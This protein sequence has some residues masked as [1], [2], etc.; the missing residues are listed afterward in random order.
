M[1]QACY[2]STVALIALALPAAVHAQSSGSSSTEDQANSDDVIVVVADRIPGQVDTNV[3]PVLELNSEEIA[4]YGANSIADL[5]AALAPQTN[6]NRGRGGGQPVFLINGVRV[7]SFREFFAYPPEAIEKTEVL[8]EEVAQKFGF[9]PDRRVVNFVL[10]N[11]YSAITL[12]GEYEQP[13]RGG[14]SVNEQQVT[15]LKITG[16]GR[17]NVNAER[18]AT[19]LLTEAERNIIQT[20]ASIPG[21]PTDPDPAAFRSLVGEAER[22]EASANYAKA[23]VSSGSSLSLNA[24]INRS[25]TTGLSGLNTVVL[26]RGTDSVIRTFGEDD[27]LATRARTDSFSTAGSY[28]LPV[29]G[30]TLTATADANFTDTRTLIDRR[31]DVTQ[32]VADAASG[33]LDIRGVLPSL[34]DAGFD[35]ANRETATL[36]SKLTLTGSPL[37]LPGGEVQTTLDA[38][39]RWNRIKSD[40]TRSGTAT[41]LSRNRVSTGLNVTVPVTSRREGFLD[42]VGSITLN[43]NIGIDEISDFGTLK[44]WTAGVTWEPVDGLD[45]SAT[46]VWRE[47][48]P[49]LS[50]LGNPQIVSLNVPTFDLTNNTTELVSVTSGGNPALLAEQQSDWSFSANWRL[51]FIE[52]GRLN[53]TY[54]VNRSSNVASN[55][56]FLTPEIEAAFPDRVTR[57]TAGRL[58][59]LDVRPVNFFETRSKLLTFGINLGGQIGKAPARGGPPAGAAS[60]A[61]AAGGG[62]SG[63]PAGQA[64]ASSTAPGA[65]EP[66]PGGGAGADPA[67]ISEERR[68]SFMALR[69]KICAEDGEAFLLRLVEAA[70]KGE[71]IPE[72]P[73]F[74]PAQAERM[75]ARLR[76]DDGSINV[77][78]V[79]GFRTMM[80]SADSPFGGRPAGGPPAQASG[81][82]ATASGSSSGSGGSRAAAFFGGGGDSRVRYFLSLTHSIELERE[83]LIAPGGPLLDLLDGDTLTSTGNARQSSRLEAGLF[84]GGTGFRLTGR[85]TGKAR[86]N[87]TGLPGSTDLFVD[88]LAR[89]DIRIFADMGQVLKKDDGVFKN[90]RISFVVDNVFDGRRL[91]RD[92]NGDTPIGFQPLLIDPTGRYL[93]IDIRKLF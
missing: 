65:G 85:Y 24:T 34:P 30:F 37:F 48:A 72:L 73:E 74:D 43:G 33:V 91:V 81:G 80:C 78:R 19:S 16:G 92:S 38:G 58:T 77:E 53:A 10:K 42:A 47:E 86:I 75:L 63:S 28:N 79:K 60:A 57:D 8:P 36:D 82:P 35:T 29:G 93:G 88:D 89:F 11:N 15:L 13:D 5:V 59:E 21:V 2:L 4:A 20:G 1:I 49:S 51:P 87:G 69:E 68:A 32:L 71:T 26:S 61:G 3:A 39:Y 52:N 12:E 17:L 70:S 54:V 83:V 7:A 55:F 27:P 31:A 66:P 25:D 76:N 46:Y 90:M 22:Y 67:G 62:A 23:F 41:D 6:S 9:P 64:P 84:K 14:Y 50:Q 40:D 56:P 18:N 44:R 45:L